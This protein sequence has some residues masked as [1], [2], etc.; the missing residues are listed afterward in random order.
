[1]AGGV[2]RNDAELDRQV[3]EMRDELRTLRA[4]D[5]LHGGRMPTPPTDV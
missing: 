3:A 2:A 5:A 4:Q 1:M